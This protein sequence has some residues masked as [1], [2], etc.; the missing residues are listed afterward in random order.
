VY[1]DLLALVGEDEMYSL[2]AGEEEGLLGGVALV[3]DDGGAREFL[4]PGC[5]EDYG[6]IVWGQASEDARPEA[7][8]QPLD[9]VVARKL[10]GAIHAFLL[11]EH[12]RT[13]I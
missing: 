4:V 3:K 9:F 13:Y 7:A 2:A 5:G 11:S 10:T 6:Q 1:D 12:S 8:G